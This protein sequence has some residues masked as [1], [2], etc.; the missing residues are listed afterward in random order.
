MAQ[1]PRLRQCKAVNTEYVS[2]S[3]SLVEPIATAASLP[4]PPNPAVDATPVDD[5]SPSACTPSAGVHE[6]DCSLDAS[7]AQ[8]SQH[9]ATPYFPVPPHASHAHAHTCHAP[10][11]VHENPLTSCPPYAQHT[12]YED[13]MDAAAAAAGAGHTSGATGAA[14]AAGRKG[15]WT[16]HECRLLESA[17]LKRR[18]E[19]DNGR[20]DWHLVARDIGGTRTAKQCRERWMNHHEVNKTSKRPW[21]YEERQFILHQLRA[22]T[23]SWSQVAAQLHNRTA[24]QVKNLAHSFRRQLDKHGNQALEKICSRSASGPVKPKAHRPV[25]HAHLVQY[26]DTETAA[27]TLPQHEHAD[28]GQRA[29]DPVHATSSRSCN[30]ID[31]VHEQEDEPSRGRGNNTEASQEHHHAHVSLPV[32][33]LHGSSV[34]AQQ[35][36]PADDDCLANSNTLRKRTK[37]ENEQLENQSPKLQKTAVELSRERSQHG[38]AGGLSPLHEQVE[39]ENDSVERQ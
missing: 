17:V 27:E 31:M 14:A 38:E 18:N 25:Q 15:P 6:T 29:A 21:A 20:I 35:S 28:N 9:V 32:A 12:S 34:H 33:Y 39:T 10:V 13:A 16:E 30:Y 11:A 5:A 8:P 4:P 23:N 36:V 26:T 22:G 19:C 1:L 37:H 24:G 3:T 7:Q 2:V